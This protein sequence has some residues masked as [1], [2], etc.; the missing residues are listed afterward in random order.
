MSSSEFI[1]EAEETSLKKEGWKLQMVGAKDDGCLEE[2][3]ARLKKIVLENGGKLLRDV[4]IIQGFYALLPP[5]Q[6]SVFSENASKHASFI[7]DD[8][9]VS[10]NE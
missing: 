7:E 2:N 8:K 6:V 9:Q 4:P 3:I 10:I 1:S 5:N